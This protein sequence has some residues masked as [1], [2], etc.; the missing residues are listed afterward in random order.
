MT[1]RIVM[2]H[3]TFRKSLRFEGFVRACATAGMAQVSVW[4]DEVAAIGL[5][6]AQALLDDLGLM[7][8]GYN[9]AGPLLA[10]PDARQAALD[11]AR[12]E[13]DTAAALG[14]DH[15]LVFPGG[16][17]AGARGLAAA[18]AE[19]AEAVSR[20]L[21][22]ARGCGVGLALEPL[23]P[24]LAGD[25]T[26]LCTMAEANALCAA[27]GPGL[28]IVIDTHHVWWDPALADQI[29]IAGAA[30]RIMGLHVNDWLRPTTDFLTDRGMMGDGI[31]D[32]R[33]IFD[34]TRRAGYRGPVEV[35]IFSERW[36]AEPPDAVMALALA[37]CAAIFGDEAPE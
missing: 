13:I 10:V 20:L 18:R 36:W 34:T 2:N 35:E 8:F 32:L 4:G 29:A 11:D 19:T 23:H 33:G 37:R 21:D 26:S 7:V 9:R 31:I 1:P 30:G 6:R 22:H 17:P 16:L 5:P 27:A 14:A 24:M 15:V 25:R 12:H 28:G 3:A